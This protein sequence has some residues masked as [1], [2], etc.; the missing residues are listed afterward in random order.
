[1]LDGLLHYYYY[2]YYYYYYHY[3]HYHYHYHSPYV[4]HMVGMSLVLNGKGWK[5]T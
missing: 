5:R 4:E 1:M 3:H 2:Y